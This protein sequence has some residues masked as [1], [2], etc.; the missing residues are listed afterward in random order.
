MSTIRRFEDLEVW[1]KARELT[2]L[3]YKITSDSQFVKDLR[4]RNQMRGAAVS[5]MSNIS[6]GFCRSS[7]K[8]FI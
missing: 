4:L 7:D 6:E 1:K 3:V 5:I 8:E 2:K